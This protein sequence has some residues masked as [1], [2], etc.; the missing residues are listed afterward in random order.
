MPALPDLFV[1]RMR[2]RLGD[3]I[4]AF[5]D[6]LQQTS[7]VSIRLHH[8]KGKCNYP[9]DN[10]VAWCKAGYY[11]QERPEFHLDPHWHGGAYYVQEASSMALDYVLSQLRLE[12]KPRV[13]LDMCAAPGGKTGILASHMRPADI[14]IANEVVA[15]RRSVLYENL[16][17]GGNPQMCIT[18]LDAAAF[19]TPLADIMLIDAPCA[20]EGMMRKDSA[21]VAQWNPG[22][23]KSCSILQQ[24]IVSKAIRCLQPGGY[25]VYSTCSYSDEENIVNVAHYCHEYGLSPISI[26]FPEEWGIVTAEYQGAMGYHFY[27]H[28]VRGEGLFIAVLQQNAQQT[29]QKK[30]GGKPTRG[31]DN[32]PPQVG[33][34]LDHPE[35]YVVV[36]N[37]SSNPLIRKEAIEKAAEV[38]H[39][40]PSAKWICEAGEIKGKDFIPSPYLAMSGLYHHGDPQ[41]GLDLDQALS[42]LERDTRGLP[43]DLPNGWYMVGYQQTVLGWAKHTQNGWKNHY[44]LPW[45]LRSRKK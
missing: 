24:Q 32:L 36:K 15:Q 28:R 22:L 35:E 3:E 42:Y 5:L 14:L 27:P 23:V 43:A 9:L 7:P 37:H 20:G 33:L 4:S 19:S 18:G 8:Q 44:P 38:W 30:H 1:K 12:D 2:E 17:K 25:L 29:F 16:V 11:L 39:S 13:W 45:R 41:I 6:S 26:E 34:F 40:L 21:A 10:K 31:F